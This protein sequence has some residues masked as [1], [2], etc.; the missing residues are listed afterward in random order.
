MRQDW[1]DED[2]LCRIREG[3][4][5]PE[6]YVIL[7]GDPK[8]CEITARYLDDAWLETNGREFPMY[9][10]YIDGEPVCV[11]A[12]AGMDRM[13]GESVGAGS[14][15]GAVAALEWLAKRGADTFVWVGTCQGMELEVKSS[16]IVIANGAVRMRGPAEKGAP[17]EFPA[18]AGYAVVNALAEAAE[19]SGQV[20]HVGVVRGKPEAEGGED[21]REE[22]LKLGCM[23]VEPESAPLFIAGSYLRVRVG[24]LFL[25][26]SN[27]ARERCGLINP[28]V[29]N[30]E[31][32]AQIAVEGLR[33]LIRQDR[34]GRRLV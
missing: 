12:V 27:R 14:S 7:T 19:S 3:K 34:K 29:Y 23:A 1:D 25:V 13:D 32:A 28:V 26:T 31:A 16:D 8:Q 9:T 5:V 33:V 2:R 22:W 18:V 21:L 15:I 4:R 24:S 30:K 6:R 11:G 17:V 10:G 20:Y